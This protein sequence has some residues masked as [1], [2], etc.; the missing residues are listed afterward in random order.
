MFND[1]S[2]KYIDLYYIYILLMIYHIYI[3]YILSL[4]ISIW[5]YIYIHRRSF[6]PARGSRSC[7]PPGC[8]CH[9]PAQPQGKDG[10]WVG[11]LGG[12]M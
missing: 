5:I 6:L 10:S 7:R 4:E 9:P 8:R 11:R 2:D 3:S 12:D 1:I